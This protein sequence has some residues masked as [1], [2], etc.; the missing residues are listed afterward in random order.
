M[1]RFDTWKFIFW[2]PLAVRIASRRLNQPLA[3]PSATL[4][5]YGNLALSYAVPTWYAPL[6]QA[7][8]AETRRRPRRPLLYVARANR[9][10][11][12]P[13]QHNL[14]KSIALGS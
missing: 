10:S 7:Q 5:G 13:Q 4:P 11:A 2:G 12:P 14:A 1:F 6:A 9:A 8:Y 3:S